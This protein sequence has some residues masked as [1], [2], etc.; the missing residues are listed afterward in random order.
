MREEGCDRWQE[1]HAEGARAAALHEGTSFAGPIISKATKESVQAIN[2]AVRA[3][4]AHNTDEGV[5]Q[6]NLAIVAQARA[7]L[8]HQQKEELL[9]KRLQ[10]QKHQRQQARE[11]QAANLEQLKQWSVS[12][13]GRP[14]FA[15]ALEA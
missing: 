10:E 15:S 11:A 3:R 14:K 4:A 7:G 6:N 9:S 12:Q 5:A 1:L 8:H 2:D 13:V